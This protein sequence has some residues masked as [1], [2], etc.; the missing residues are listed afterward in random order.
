M[1]GKNKS[2]NQ[3]ISGI[4]NGSAQANTEDSAA[5]LEYYK[6]V[7][8]RLRDRKRRAKS[9]QKEELPQEA[10]YS[11]SSNEPIEKA[12]VPQIKQNVKQM[13]RNPPQNIPPNQTSI[14]EKKA[15]PYQELVKE[16]NNTKVDAIQQNL[17]HFENNPPKKNPP[18]QT[19]I[20]VK[21]GS[22]QETHNTLL[23]KE[24][25]KNA[26]NT[27]VER[28]KQNEKKTALTPPK[29]SSIDLPKNWREHRPNTA[30]QLSSKVF[31]R[32]GFSKNEGT[33]QNFQM[34][35]TSREAV[36]REKSL[37]VDS[38]RPSLSETVGNNAKGQSNDLPKP[39]P[40]QQKKRTPKKKME[41][42]AIPKV[43]TNGEQAFLVGEIAAVLIPKHLLGPNISTAQPVAPVDVSVDS[44]VVSAAQTQESVKEADE[45]SLKDTENH[46][47]EL[48]IGQDGE[49]MVRVTVLPIP[50]EPSKR[51]KKKLERKRD[52]QK[53][54]EGKAV[55]DEQDGANVERD[56]SSND[57]SSSSDELSRPRPS[58]N[59]PIIFSIRKTEL[60]SFR[61]RGVQALKHISPKFPRAIFICRLCSFHI[62]SIPE[63]HRHMKDERHIRLQHQDLSRQTAKVMPN[64]SPVIVDAVE[65]FIQDIYLCSGLSKEDLELRRSAIELLKKAVEVAFPGFSIRPYGSYITGCLFLLHFGEMRLLIYFIYL[66]G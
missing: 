34:P 45:S 49:E 35:S 53:V 66:F 51:A 56:S 63:V 29:Q 25:F 48:T 27:K 10:L 40:P 64:P 65:Q 36:L 46:Q 50:L 21:K 16:A 14:K 58:N 5:L 44:T 17:K 37:S 12:K 8:K 55:D 54:E 47:E 26:N 1:N 4:S 38:K 15:K 3:T 60:F 31:T 42:K 2:S 61:R 19:S 24:S 62:S 28:V 39:K 41:A 59:Q 7:K 43:E 13:T 20:E 11:L 6:A 57:S 30:P 9:K 32:G 52:A 18:K 23:T 33:P 22:L